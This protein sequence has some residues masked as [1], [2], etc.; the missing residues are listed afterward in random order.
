[1]SLLSED[2][3]VLATVGCVCCFYPVQAL[4]RACGLLPLLWFSCSALQLFSVGVQND[5]KPNHVSPAKRIPILWIS[6]CPYCG[7]QAFIDLVFSL[8]LWPHFFL[9]VYIYIYTHIYIVS[10]YMYIELVISS[11]SFILVSWSQESNKLIIFPVG[12]NIL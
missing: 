2:I 8:W 6:P 3:E 7:L 10:L 12:S 9:I 1:M 11:E 4:S 5:T